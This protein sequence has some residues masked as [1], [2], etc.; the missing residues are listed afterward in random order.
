VSYAQDILGDDALFRRARLQEE[1]FRDE[2][3]AMELYQEL[4]IRY[5]GSVY[6]IDAR[7]R[8]RYLRGDIE[9]LPEEDI[10]F[11]KLDQ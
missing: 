8:F 7:R 2:E 11:Y 1:I 3:K 4:L 10:F 5:P 6:T 9:K